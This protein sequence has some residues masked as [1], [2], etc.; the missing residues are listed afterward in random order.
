M[1]KEEVD[2]K[3]QEINQTDLDLDSPLKCGL[4][5]REISELKASGVKKPQSVSW[6]DWNGPLKLSHRHLF[7]CYLAASGMKAREI[8]REIQMEDS[9]ISILLNSEALKTKIEL[10]RDVQFRGTA[11]EQQMDALSTQ[12]ARIA[13]DLLASDNTNDNLKWR[14]AKDTLDRKLGKPVHRTQVEGG[15]MFTEMFK[16]LQQERIQNLE[17]KKLPSPMNDLNN[18]N[19]SQD[20]NEREIIDVTSTEE[21]VK[22]KE[23][24]E[25]KEEDEKEDF[26]GFWEQQ[27]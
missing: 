26:S 14:I 9:R 17:G 13:R 5:R 7:I 20:E 16:W 8:A 21:T 6:S 24:T 23:E 3:I 12:A 27:N 19:E 22:K 18:L 15:S 4:S 2:Q 11:T 1:K 10:I 25:E